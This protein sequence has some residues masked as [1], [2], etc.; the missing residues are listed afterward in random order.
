MC[1]FLLKFTPVAIY[2]GVHRFRVQGFKVTHLQN[3]CNQI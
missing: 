1:V 3:P 2:V